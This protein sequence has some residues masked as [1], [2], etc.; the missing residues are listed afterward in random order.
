MLASQALSL[1]FPILASRQKLSIRH[2]DSGVKHSLID[3]NV[4]GVELPQIVK[5][6][7]SLD[8]TEARA[9][10]GHSCL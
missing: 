5:E 7:G 6:F 8:P 3:Q 1:R 10:G 2:H 4:S 9:E